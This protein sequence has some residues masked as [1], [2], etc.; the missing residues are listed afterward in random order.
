M[1][2]NINIERKCIYCGNLFNAKTYVTKYCSHTCNRRHY[3]ELKKNERVQND[4]SLPTQAIVGAVL[5][6]LVNEYLSIS[7]T[8]TVL[9]LSDRSIFRM[10]NKKVIQPI[11]IGRRVLINKKE[12]TKML[13]YENRIEAKKT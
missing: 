4:Q 9:R 1:S 13:E 7:E 3:K 2:S 12:I 5:A 6:P 8:A 11:K 10:L